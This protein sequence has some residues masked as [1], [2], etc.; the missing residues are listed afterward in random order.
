MSVVVATALDLFVRRVK[1][2]A[3]GTGTAGGVGGSRVRTFLI[4]ASGRGRPAFSPL[5]F[6]DNLLL[7]DILQ[8]WGKAN[9]N[10]RPTDIVHFDLSLLHC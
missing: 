8:R 5:V 6:V 3:G 10:P 1:D 2:R 4:S 9:F 7:L